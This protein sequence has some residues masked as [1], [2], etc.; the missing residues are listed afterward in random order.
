MTEK[1]DLK[2]LFDVFVW[3]SKVWF[4]LYFGQGLDRKI[5]KQGKSI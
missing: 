4:F 5:A 1:M 2:V 3:E